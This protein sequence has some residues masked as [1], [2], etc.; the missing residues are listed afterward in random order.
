ME[1]SK[2]TQESGTAR[3]DFRRGKRP[4]PGWGWTAGAFFM[5]LLGALTVLLI[6]WLFGRTLAL[7]VLGLAIAAALAPVVTRLEHR[8][9]RIFAI[10]LVYLIIFLLFVLM[11]LLI[12]PAIIEQGAE[13]VA[14]IP[15]I[16][17]LLQEVYDAWGA[18]FP[19]V[20]TFF[21]QVLQF[22]ATL[23]AVPL[24]LASAIVQILLVFFISIYALV[25]APKMR[26]FI[27]SLFP[28]GRREKVVFVLEEMANAMGGFIRGTVMVAILVGLITFIGLSIIGVRFSLVLGLIAGIFE[29]LPY[30]GPVLASI[31]M[32]LVALLES[33]TQA[34]IV[35]IFFV[36]L[37]QLESNVFVPNIMHSQTE[38]SPLLAMFAIVAGGTLGGLLGALVAIPLA[39]AVQV[40]VV[41]VIAPLVRRQTGAGPED[42]IPDASTQLEDEQ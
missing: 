8:M 4:P 13:F 7:F 40:F 25:E 5:G 37:Q 26:S 10:L 14:L 16:I 23:A 12:I 24:G 3:P 15:D 42:E 2:H 21:N 31:P 33:P 35:L 11:S 38:I 29:L 32:L 18:E 34:L 17:D 20:E 28:P 1:N 19:L 30:L 6:L 36:I 41:L 22:T 9:R 27:E 39:A